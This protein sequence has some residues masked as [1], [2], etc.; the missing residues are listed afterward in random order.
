MATA[1]ERAGGVTL[2]ALG[3][4][5]V[6]VLIECWLV[7]YV[8][9]MI[10]GTLSFH[11]VPAPAMIVLLFVLVWCVNTPLRAFNVRY[12]LTTRE[13]LVVYTMMAVGLTAPSMGLVQVLVPALAAP[14]YYASPSNKFAEIFQLGTDKVIPSWL[15]PTDYDAIKGLFARTSTEPV[16]WGMVARTWTTPLLLW[17]LWMFVLFFV[18]ICVMAILRKP[19]VRR[20]QLTFAYNVVPEQMSATPEG[21]DETA[22]LSP[23]W[24]NKWMWVGFLIPFI[25]H[26]FA[27]LYVVSPVF[28]RIPYTFNLARYFT[29]FPWN[30]IGH[31]SLEVSFHSVAFCMLLTE[32]MLFSLWFFFLVNK[33]LAVG[34]YAFG[35]NET[36]SDFFSPAM[37]DQGTGA[38][39]MYFIII[40]WAM[41]SHLRVVVSR[42]VRFKVGDDEDD[43]ALTYRTAFWGLVL[44]MALLVGFCS[45]AGASPFCS[46]A[47]LSMILVY[48]VVLTRLVAEAGV[49]MSQAPT[50]AVHDTV[51][52]L[53]GT[54]A[55][56][57]KTWTV[58]GFFKSIFLRWYTIMPAYI[59]GGFKFADRHKINARRLVFAM[60]LAIAVSIIAGFVTTVWMDYEYGALNLSTWKADSLAKQ[61]FE[62]IRRFHDTPQGPDRKAIAVM[63]VGAGVTLLL[64]VMRMNFVWWPFHPLGYV[65]SNLYI[66]YYFWFHIFVAWVLSKLITKYG[67]LYLMRKVRPFFIGVVIGAMMSGAF[68]WVVDFFYSL[69]THWIYAI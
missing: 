68:W 53:F 61:P 67:G 40:V 58:L 12:A 60:L 39:L 35:W 32:E 20:E 24:K 22:K 63:G 7:H 11:L 9:Q 3:V 29:E 15:A 36:Y 18:Y 66:I 2:K 26:F 37:S 27:N 49:F 14:A 25:Y 19:W 52:K 59:L 30:G 62:Q 34:F 64:S 8:D 31:L 21:A 57:V 38:F 13:I 5:L 23:F 43:E 56:S 1:E 69:D 33:V 41:R 44:G 46:L 47:V 4:G 45:V 50:S 28:P 54:A 42:A 48:W 55:L 16:D 51:A 65:A 17:G 6:F 10:H